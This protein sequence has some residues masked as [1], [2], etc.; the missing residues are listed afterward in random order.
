MECN[1]HTSMLIVVLMMILSSCCYSQAQ[2][3][4]DFY[5]ESC[6]SLFPAVRRVVQR[7]VARERRMAASLLRLFFHD[8]FVN[9]CDGSILLDDTSSFVG[10][11]TAG[12]NNNSVRGFEVI[13]RIK[14]R[15]ERLCP[16][17]VSC[18]DILA[19]TARDSV[20]LLGGPRWSVKLG[21]RDSTTASLSA[22][23]S[24]VI[25]PPTS[26]LTNLINRFRA[27]GLSSRDMVA[28]SGAHTIGQARCV[29]FRNRIYNGS[30]IDRS[31][32]LSTQRSCPAATGSGDNNAAVLDSRSPGRFDVSYYKRLLNHMGLLTSD[33]VLFNGG[34]T[35]SLVI[36]YSRSLNRFYR[37]FV[38]A[39]IKMG[40]ISPLTGSNGQIRT[41]CRRPN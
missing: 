37:D 21:R 31:F 34:S 7:A 4:S 2:L 39:M 12:P 33:Q 24:G 30:N 27:Q 15:V 14:S 11:K 23:N 38:R 6:P 10:E 25:P 36:A 20:L 1:T 16:G 3:S 18:A 29:T 13:D 8:C 26:T 40:D 5:S 22:A 41:N 35:D 32:A 28:L 9:G 17:V 19:I